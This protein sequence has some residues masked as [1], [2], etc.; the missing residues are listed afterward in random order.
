V[1][2]QPYSNGRRRFGLWGL[3]SMEPEIA[4]K[5]RIDERELEAGGLN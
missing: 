2:A 3:E 5:L 1:T 4:A